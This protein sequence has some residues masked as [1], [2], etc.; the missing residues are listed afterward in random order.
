MDPS[1]GETWEQERAARAGTALKQH[2]CQEKY[3]RNHSFRVDV[4]P[5][6]SWSHLRQSPSLL[7]G[8]LAL[9]DTSDHIIIALPLT[10]RAFLLKDVYKAQLFLRQQWEL[11]LSKPF[12]WLFWTGGF[13]VSF[14]TWALNSS[15]W[16]IL[17]FIN[18]NVSFLSVIP[19]KS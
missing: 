18:E 15:T 13:L 16:A 6:G 4:W 2:C 14:V 7:S 5:S 3:S 8:T 19:Q 17:L 11:R 10:V 1:K 9:P 12:R